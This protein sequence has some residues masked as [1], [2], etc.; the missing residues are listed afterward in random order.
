[1]TAH[2]SSS[3]GVGTVRKAIRLLECLAERSDP[4]G[5]TEIARAAGLNKATAH[6]LLTILKDGGL[7]R[8]DGEDRRYALG[9]RLVQLGMH[10]LE[11]IEIPRLARPHMAALMRESRQTVHLA[12]LEDSAVVY[13]EKVE[14]L[15][16]VILRSRVGGTPPIHATSVGK[17]LLAFL[18]PEDRDAL[19]ARLL[20]P[21]F[22][23]HT[24]TN[25]TGFRRHLEE[26]RRR[27]YAVDNEEHREGIRCVGAPIFDASSRVVAAVSIAGPAFRIPQG[28]I[29]RMARQ[30]IRC[31]TAIS[32]AL[33][34]REATPPRARVGRQGA[35]GWGTSRG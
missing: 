12:S 4:L 22:T 1:M 23:S 7:V 16:G 28:T 15:E 34:H 33:G 27:G 11:R 13:I 9:L 14:G 32:A 3:I 30:V 17:C 20:L 31:A 24:I 35:I 25:R 26:V 29:P 8:Q 6:R 21:G 5:R 19:L 2:G 10:A 18:P